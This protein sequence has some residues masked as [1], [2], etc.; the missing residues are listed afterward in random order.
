M[1]SIKHQ[2]SVEHC[3][4]SYCIR[5]DSYIAL[6]E[7]QLPPVSCPECK[8]SFSHKASL[9]A[10][11]REKLHAFCNH[12]SIL[13]PT[14]ELHESHA[15]SHTPVPVRQPTPATQFRCCDCK[16]NFR[17]EDALT[18]HLRCRGIHKP[19]KGG[20][21]TKKQEQARS[22]QVTPQ[23]R[24]EKCKKSFKNQD[25][26]TQHLSSVRHHPLS[27]IK[28]LADAKCKKHFNCP[29]AQL[30]HLE[31]GKCTSGMTKTIL[32]NAIASKDTARIITS[33]AVLPQ[34]LLGNQSVSTSSTS[35]SRSP[36]LTPTSTTFSG[37]YPSSVVLTPVSASSNTANFHSALTE[38]LRAQNGFHKCH[39]CPP[40]R[41]RQYTTSGLQSH[42]SSSVHAQVSVILPAPDDISFH[43]P[44]TLVRGGVQK[45]PVKHFAT[46][47]ALAQHLESG[48]CEGGI[49][50]M[51]S[52][53]KYVQEEMKGAGFGE[54]KLLS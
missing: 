44:R 14:R 20:K 4:C 10:H 37:S 54:M 26:L 33:R 21:N 34:R 52:V 48:A 45:K 1:T 36:I 8:Q 32:N 43:C 39:L 51:R 41:K 30:L 31:S 46:V 25:S 19:S 29:S 35:Q 40:S 16:R 24:C 27:N 53:I 49:G 9:I 13:F 11:Q 15:Q 38:R 22:E 7:A 17:S 50:T 5:L 42:L 23:T 6:L 3:P 12:C 28:C 47:S 18:N 2:D